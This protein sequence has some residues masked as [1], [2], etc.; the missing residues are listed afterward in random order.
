MLWSK[1]ENIDSWINAIEDFNGE[2]IV[3]MF[4]ENNSKEKSSSFELKF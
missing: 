3:G 4:Y 2:E 1:F